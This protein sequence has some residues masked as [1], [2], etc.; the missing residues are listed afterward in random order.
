MIKILKLMTET[1]RHKKYLHIY[2]QYIFL[3]EIC[4]HCSYSVR[5]QIKADSKSPTDEHPTL[6]CKFRIA[7]PNTQRTSA[8]ICNGFFQYISNLSNT[9]D[10]FL[11]KKMTNK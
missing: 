4:K 5:L 1:Y 8:I 11:F 10:V 2:I 7:S 6:K 9:C 3:H